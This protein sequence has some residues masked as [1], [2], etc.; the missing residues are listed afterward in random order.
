MQKTGRNIEKGRGSSYRKRG[1]G[2]GG[3]RNELPQASK[4]GHQKKKAFAGNHEGADILN[5]IND[6]EA[7]EE[8]IAFTAIA[9][10]IL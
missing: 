10:R 9:T 3:R 2:R 5:P 6:S 8:Q 7:G 1:L 4:R